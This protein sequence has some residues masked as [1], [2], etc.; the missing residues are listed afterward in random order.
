MCVC[1]A[2]MLLC[3]FFLFS[4][5]FDL[6]F[7]FLPAQQVDYKDAKTLF[8]IRVFYSSSMLFIQVLQ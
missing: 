7:D 1:F 6:V 4:F 2:S 8:K 5:I 3:S